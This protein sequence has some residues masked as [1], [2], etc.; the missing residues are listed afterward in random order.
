[1]QYRSAAFHAAPLGG[2][3]GDRLG[4]LL[5][6][7]VATTTLNSVGVRGIVCAVP[8]EPVAVE[9]SGNAFT[10]NEVAQIAKTVGLRQTYRSAPGQTAG[11]L[12]TEAAG[13]LLADLGWEPA[14][15]DGIILVTQNPD[16]FSPATAC[17]AHGRLGLADHCLAFDVGMGCSGYVYGML[18]AGQFIA[19]GACKRVLLLAGDTP[20]QAISPEDKSVA[21]LFGD[22]GTATALEYDPSADAMAFVLGTDGTGADNLV[23][24]AGG[25][26]ERPNARCFDRE[27]DEDGN[28]RSSLELKMNGLAV[29]A[30]TLQRVPPLVTATL[31]ARGWEKDDVDAFLFHQAN[32]FMLTKIGK[33]L[34]LPPDRT[35][36]NIDR[37]GNTSMGSIPLLL[38]DDLAARLRSGEPVRTLMAGF[39]VGYSWAGLATTLRG[40]ESARVIHV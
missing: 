36:T 23:I 27:A 20:S 34:G 38:A 8:G 33:K 39:G 31:A 16:H 25:F 19:S 15:V 28:R 5:G 18:I 21:M 4:F 6:S 22:A 10:A 1:M 12:C 3:G 11:D 14:S 35:P 32:G 37:Y 2:P 9:A 7:V 13:A 40:L 17:I 30:F 24:P 29:F 26:R